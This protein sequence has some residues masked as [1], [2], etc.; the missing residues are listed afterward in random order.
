MTGMNLGDIKST[1]LLYAKGL[2]FVILSA[3]SSGM[4]IAEHPKVSTIVLLAI[5]IWASARAYYF[6]FYVIEKYVDPDF[7]FSG[8]TAFLRYLWRKKSQDT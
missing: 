3:M 7:R 5:S 2:S 8:L 6:A 1:R 4:L